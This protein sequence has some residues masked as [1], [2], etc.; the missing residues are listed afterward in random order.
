MKSMILAM[1]QP[2]AMCST[3]KCMGK[4]MEKAWGIAKSLSPGLLVSG[5]ASMMKTTKGVSKESPEVQE[6][7]RYNT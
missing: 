5:A 4:I 2:S 6:N 1:F 7:F 3:K